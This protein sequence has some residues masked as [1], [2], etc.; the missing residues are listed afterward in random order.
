MTYNK[1]RGYH[2]RDINAIQVVVGST[3]NGT[4]DFNTITKIKK[5]QV[6]QGL[7]GDGRFGPKSKT[8][9]DAIVKA[10]V[11][12]NKGKGFT[13]DQIKKI[14]RKVGSKDDGVWGPKTVKHLMVWQKNMIILNPTGVFNMSTKI[15][16]FGVGGL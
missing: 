3:P 1:Q 13:V 8:K 11:T 4:Y 5:W 9:F 2:T 15:L 10:A 6:E 14:Q 12:V 7:K 16:M